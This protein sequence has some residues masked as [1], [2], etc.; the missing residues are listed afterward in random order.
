MKKI[1]SI[2]K[3]LKGSHLHKNNVAFLYEMLKQYVNN[4]NIRGT[5]GT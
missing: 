3:L 5:K 1:K 2:D 4:I